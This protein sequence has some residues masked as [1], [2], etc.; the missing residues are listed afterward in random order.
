VS[1]NYPDYFPKPRHTLGLA[2]IGLL[3]AMLG[4]AASVAVF[5]FGFILAP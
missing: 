1:E 5:V 2:G 3:V 4:V